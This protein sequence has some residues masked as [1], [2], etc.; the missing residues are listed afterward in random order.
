MGGILPIGCVLL[1]FRW[2]V[3][4]YWNS[5]FGIDSHKIIDFKGPRGFLSFWG[6]SGVTFGSLL[7]SKVVFGMILEASKK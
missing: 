7:V 5:D 1:G 4:K 2:V 3:N 6:F